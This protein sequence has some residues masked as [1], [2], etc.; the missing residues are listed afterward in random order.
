ME[1]FLAKLV[2]RFQTAS[3]ESQ[4]QFDE[5]LRLVLAED[6][7][8]AFHKAQLIGQQEQLVAEE[9]SP[10]QVNWIFMDVIEIYPL[11]KMMDGAEVLSQISQP[12]DK[13]RYQLEVRL[14]AGY[15]LSSCTERFLQAL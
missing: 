15:L 2:Y 6:N 4:T 10:H 7:L 11:H 5:Q 3:N 13:D 8:H 12:A 9:H 14:K 1:W